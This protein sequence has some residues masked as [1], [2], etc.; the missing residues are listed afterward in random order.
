MTT[1]SFVEWNVREVS[2]K[3]LQIIYEFSA[4]I[5]SKSP[6]EWFE[7]SRRKQK[8]DRKGGSRMK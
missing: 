8:E 4:N 3:Y 1:A 5:L 6:L 2:I 7:F